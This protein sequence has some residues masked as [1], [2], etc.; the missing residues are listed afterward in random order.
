MSLFYHALAYTFEC[1][2]FIFM[3]IIFVIY[4]LAW[5]MVSVY[6]LI[7]ILIII[8]VARFVNIVVITAI[9]NYEFPKN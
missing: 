5:E 9:Y 8:L 2:T 1:L 6:T 3:G 7:V 4:P